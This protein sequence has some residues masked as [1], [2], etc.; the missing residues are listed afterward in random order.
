[1]SLPPQHPGQ[2]PMPVIAAPRPV[3]PDYVSLNAKWCGDKPAFI[4]GDE[5][6]T[7]RAFSGRVN[8]VVRGLRTLGVTPRD[9]VGVVMD[10]SLAMA[11]IIWGIMAAGAA[12]VPLNT[13]ISD[14]AMLAMLRDAGVRAV[15][16]S[17][18]HVQCVTAIQSQLAGLLPDASI[19]VEGAAPGWQDYSQWRAQFETGPL[20]VE[21][22][23]ESTCNIIYSSGTTGQPKGIVHSHQRRLDWAGDLA[24]ALRYTS[25]SVTLASIG[26]YSNIVWVG[27]LATVISGGTIVIMPKFDARAALELIA[28]HRITNTAMVPL[29]YDMML[30]ADD[31]QIGVSS[32]TAMM[33]AG[34]PLWEDL[35]RNLIGRFGPTII[36]LYGLT[37]GLIT[38]LAPEDAARKLSSVGKPVL[39]SDLRIVDDDGRDVPHGQT[40]E[41]VGLSRFV[42]DGYLNRP[43]ATNDAVLVDSDGRHWLKTGDLGKLDDEGFLYIVGRKKDLILSGGQNIYPADIEAVAIKHPDVADVAVIGVPHAKWGETPLA[44]IVARQSAANEDEIRD[45]INAHVGKQQRISAVEFRAALPRNPNGKLLKAELRAPYW[46]QTRSQA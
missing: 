16:A 30:A 13:S 3:L 15:F 45:W 44:L 40:G 18:A 46:S 9:H 38:T 23:P 27:M 29:Q 17:R 32:I 22:D 10:N 6:L 14:E 8:Q 7:W 34:S 31:G 11:E 26:M 39:G 1:M 5:V 33:S 43:D 28:R 35:K 37:E 20:R 24:I 21:V 42:M 41:I 36:E 25:A 12:V 4:C 2:N 19:A